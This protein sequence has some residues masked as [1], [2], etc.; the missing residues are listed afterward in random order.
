MSPVGDVIVATLGDTI[1]VE[2]GLHAGF[3]LAV[4]GTN[5]IFIDKPIHHLMPSNDNRLFTTGIKELTI[6]LT[7]KHTMMDASL[8]FFRSS[9]HGDVNLFSKV[10]DYLAVSDL[11][12][13]G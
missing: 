4:E 9:V 13:T 12:W 5:E 7:Y 2:M 8:G 11:T 1:I 3:Q 10:S 6:T